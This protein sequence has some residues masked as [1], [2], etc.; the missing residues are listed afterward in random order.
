MMGENKMPSFGNERQLDSINALRI[1]DLRE[2]LQ[3]SSYMQ[4]A[5]QR[6]A[7]ELTIEFMETT[8]GI[9]FR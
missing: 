8:Y 7:Q 1:R 3:E 5:V 2:K 4:A 9:P 6:I